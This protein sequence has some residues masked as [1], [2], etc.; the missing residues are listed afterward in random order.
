M[1]AETNIKM[2]E[3]SDLKGETEKRL[4]QEFLGG[5]DYQLRALSFGV[6]QRP[7]DSTQNPCLMA[8]DMITRRQINTICYAGG[9][10]MPMRRRD[11]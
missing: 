3:A 11:Y 7:A 2:G 6:M 1:A 9:P 8:L 10:R 4:W 5:F